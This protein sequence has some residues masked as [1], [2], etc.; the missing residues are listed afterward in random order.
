V[1]R[2]PIGPISSSTANPCRHTRG[3]AKGTVFPPGWPENANTV[4]SR[5]STS[6]GRHI[7]IHNAARLPPGDQRD[8]LCAANLRS[9]LCLRRRG[10]NRLQGVLG[11]DAVR[12]E[13]TTPPRELG[14]L[15]M[16][17]DAI[18]NAVEREFLEQEQ[19][20]A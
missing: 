6:Q 8:A 2:R 13:A 17:F 16:A 3:A 7:H 20:T 1:H 11:F 18:A 10:V 5:F 15:S 12:A 4:A 9:W 19:G 14:L